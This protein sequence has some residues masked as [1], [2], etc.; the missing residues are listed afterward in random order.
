MSNVF[1]IPA[2]SDPKVAESV[3]K[4][5]QDIS[6]QMTMKESYAAAV[7]EAIKGVSDE[8]DIPKK[9]IRALARAYHRQTFRTEVEENELFEEAYTKV[10]GDD[11]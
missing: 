10:F 9:V 5:I 7:T 8:H 11:D 2:L 6:D 3:K 1:D 4:S